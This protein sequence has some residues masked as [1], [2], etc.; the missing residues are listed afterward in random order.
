M[1]GGQ[2]GADPG[3]PKGYTDWPVNRL[4]GALLVPTTIPSRGFDKILRTGYWINADNP[5]GATTSFVPDTFY[6][7]SV[8]YGP[9]TD[10][11]YMKLQRATRVRQPSRLIALADGVY[12]G[13]QRDAR[14]GVTNSRVGYRHPGDRA[15]ALCADG[16]VE[17]VRGDAFPRAVGGTVTLDD[18]RADNLNGPL[19]VYA[20]P[21]RSLLN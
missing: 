6:T 10:G 18:A 9:A 17:A 11:T 8:G 12:A 13:R 7:N 14:R 1:A 19:T 20:D 3:K 21:R 4:A 15:N 5:I 2:T 16:H